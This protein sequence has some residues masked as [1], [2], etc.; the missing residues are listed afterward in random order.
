[1]KLCEIK[2]EGKKFYTLVITED[3]MNDL[4][5]PPYEKPL[6]LNYITPN[7]EAVQFEVSVKFL[8]IKS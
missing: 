3:E 4:F 2:E 1:M 5:N 8:N 7:F 6:F